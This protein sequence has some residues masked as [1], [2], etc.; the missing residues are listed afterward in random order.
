MGQDPGPATAPVPARAA[1]SD[2]ET[3][4]DDGMVTRRNGRDVSRFIRHHHSLGAGSR[5]S[6]RKTDR[7]F[8]GQSSTS[9]PSLCRCG[10]TDRSR[11]GSRRIRRKSPD[12]PDLGPRRLEDRERHRAASPEGS[13]TQTHRD[14]VD[15]QDSC[16]SKPVIPTIFSWR[17]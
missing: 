4:E 5:Q 14:P 6:S 2:P 16:S 15:N 17:I 10:S 8:S 12:C 1:V 9:R 7:R 3:E 11:H 13:A